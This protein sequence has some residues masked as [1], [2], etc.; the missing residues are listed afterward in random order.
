MGLL[1]ASYQLPSEPRHKETLVVPSPLRSAGGVGTISHHAERSPS[2]CVG[3][4][5]AAD[6]ACPDTV[7]DPALPS[8]TAC[9]T[10]PP[11]W[12]LPSRCV[13]RMRRSVPML[14]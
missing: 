9:T 5:Y 7:A 10:R 11:H 12:P 1:P 4:E 13:T 3:Q 2:L 6:T 14:G 8:S